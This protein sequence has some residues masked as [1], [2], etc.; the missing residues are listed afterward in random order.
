MG[1]SQRAG[2]HPRYE[3]KEYDPAGRKNT[4][5]FVVAPDRPGDALW[6]NQ[7]TWFALLDA[8]AGTTAT[9][10]LQKPESGVYLFVIEGSI[11]VGEIALSRRDGVG[12][13]D[14]DKVDI[15]ATEDS[16]ILVME[17]PMQ[18]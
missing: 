6:V 13:E 7:D 4:W 2:H 3:Q 10:T 17:V 5:Q 12:L 16:R 8:D 14:L 18:W 15:A 1:V 11:T 9:Y